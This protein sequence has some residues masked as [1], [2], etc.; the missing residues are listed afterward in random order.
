MCPKLIDLKSLSGAL[1]IANYL[2]NYYFICNCYDKT[3]I[4]SKYLPQT[5]YTSRFFDIT[6]K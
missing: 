1:F 4:H 3:A 2:R 5:Q 6:S